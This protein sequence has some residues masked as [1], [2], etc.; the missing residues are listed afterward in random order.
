MIVILCSHE[1][2]GQIVRSPTDRAIVP[3]P[4]LLRNFSHMLDTLYGMSAAKSKPPWLLEP[5]VVP[6]DGTLRSPNYTAS[7]SYPCADGKCSEEYERRSAPRSLPPTRRVNGLNL[8][9]DF[10]FH[11]HPRPK[12]YT[13]PPH[14]LRI[15]AERDD[16]TPV[17]PT[18]HPLIW[19]NGNIDQF[20]VRVLEK[21]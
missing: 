3:V 7:F 4:P 1:S 13:P 6:L 21:K 5:R 10:G 2:D 8:R 11:P 9:Y 19:I 20:S 15:T 12:S 14:T 17:S 18:S 16:P